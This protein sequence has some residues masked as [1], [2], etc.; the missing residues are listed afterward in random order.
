L[1]KDKTSSTTSPATEVS[2]AIGLLNRRGGV[3]F[4]DIVETEA[5]KAENIGK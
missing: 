4:G 1:N 5:E 3:I 2:E